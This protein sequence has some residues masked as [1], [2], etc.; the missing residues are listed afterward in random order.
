MN[1]MTPS[2]RLRARIAH[3]PDRSTLPR[4]TARHSPIAAAV[5]A[6]G[7]RRTQFHEGYSAM[8]SGNRIPSLRRP[9]LLVL[10]T[11]SGIGAATAQID[12]TSFGS[13]ALSS[14]SGSYNSAFG[15]SALNL[16][17]TGERNTADGW[18]ALQM[19][20]VGTRN[21]ATG[22]VA[23][24]NNTGSYNTADGYG[25]LYLNQGGSSNTAI[26]I[27]AL[28]SNTNGS[29]NTAA[30][31]YAL[32]YSTGNDN[33]A[34]GAYALYTNEGGSFNTAAGYNT[35]YSNQN[36]E[37][38]TAIGQAALSSNISGNN[39]LASGISA[40]GSNESGSNNTAIGSLALENATGSNNV[41]VGSQAG[42]NLTSGSNNIDIGNAG[43]AAEGGVIRIGTKGTQTKTFV[44]GIE[45]SKVTG[46]AVYVTSSG[47]LGVLA[48]SERYKTAIAPMGTN[49]AKLQQLRP[50]TFHLKTDPQGEVQYGL[51]AEEVDK[52][53][54]ELV[55]RDEAGKIQGVRYDELAPMLLNEMQ[56]EHSRIASLVAQHETD[57]M[58]IEQR[59]AMLDE[60]A[61]KIAALEQKV[62][63]VDDLRQQLAA[64]IQEL[65]VRDKL[66]AQR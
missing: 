24:Y 6:V 65:N 20:V 66:V 53:Y 41:A 49:T 31:A 56:K 10:L 36:G 28:L 12:D 34:T 51:I 26:G 17:R 7:N 33:T 29:L 9:L 58:K 64:V 47:Q 13:G 19:N 4:M 27:T 59:A 2:S 44:A 35:L 63:E 25:A 30:G 57:A 8:K 46:A 45:N 54:P 22:A 37:G 21:T 62:A 55:I 39:N 60:Q 16:N 23:L 5:A 40:L 50:V 3:Q 48:S 18:G 15:A 11:I 14:N 1:T 38:N 42:D 43:A 52:V 32:Y 61:A